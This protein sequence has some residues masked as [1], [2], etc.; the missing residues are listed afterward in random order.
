M[1]A[2]IAKIA[3]KENQNLSPQIYADDRR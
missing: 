3:G 1:I 2:M